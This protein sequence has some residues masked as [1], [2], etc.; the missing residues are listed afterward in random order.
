[1]A[2]GWIENDEKKYYSDE[3]IV[4]RN[5]ILEIDGVKY[6]FNGCGELINEGK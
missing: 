6:V 2:I 1:M 4:Q 3:G 5:T